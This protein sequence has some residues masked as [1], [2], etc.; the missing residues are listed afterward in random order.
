MSGHLSKRE[1]VLIDKHLK[2]AFAS[3]TETQKA[4]YNFAELSDSDGNVT[5]DQYE[6]HDQVSKFFESIFKNPED[7]LPTKLQLE[8]NNLQS[9]PLWQRMLEDDE[10]FQDIFSQSNIPAEIIKIISSAF[11]TTDANREKRNRAKE[12]VLKALEEPFTFE[13]FHRMIKRARGSSAGGIT[14]LSYGILKLAPEPLLEHLFEICARMWEQRYIPPYW[15]VKYLHLLVKDLSKSGLNNLRPIG[16][17]EVLRKIWSNLVIHRIRCAMYESQFFSPAQYGFISRKGTTDEL[18]Q[19]TN[20][21]EEASESNK[22]IEMTTWDITKAFDSVGRNIQFIT[23]LR[24]GV[25]IDVAKWFVDLDNGGYFIVRSPYALHHMRTLNHPTAPA[26]VVDLARQLGFQA[27]RGYTQGDVLSTTGWVGFFDILLTALEQLTDIGKFFY[28]TEGVELQAQDSMAYADDLVTVSANREQTDAY[29]EIICGFMAL[30]GLKLAPT[31]IRSSTTISPPGVLTYYDWEWRAYQR[32]FGNSDTPITILGVIMSASGSWEAQYEYLLLHCQRITQTVGHKL[33]SLSLKTKLLLCSTLAQILYRTQVIA[34]LPSQLDQ[35]NKVLFKVIRD[36]KDIG[37]TF[38]TQA[39]ITKHLGGIFTDVHS[40]TIKRKWSLQGRMLAIGGAQSKA[41]QSL[42]GRLHRTGFYDHSPSGQSAFVSTGL[43]GA[44]PRWGDDLPRSLREGIGLKYF[45]YQ[46]DDEDPLLSSMTPAP[47]VECAEVLE[48][49]SIYYRSELTPDGSTIPDWLHPRNMPEFRQG[50]RHLLESNLIQDPVGEP[51]AEPSCTIAPDQLYTFIGADYEEI[52]FEV[53]GILP[54]GLIA[55][56]RWKRVSRQSKKLVPC[57]EHDSQGRA[58]PERWDPQVIPLATSRRAIAYSPCNHDREMRL[59]GTHSQL[60]GQIP[61]AMESQTPPWCTRIIHENAITLGITSMIVSDASYIRHT[62]TMHS[63]FRT[64]V[65]PPNHAE[66]AF[67]LFKPGCIRPTLGI[68]IKGMADLGNYNAFVG[69][70]LTGLGAEQFRACLPGSIELRLDCASVISATGQRLPPSSDYYVNLQEDYGTVLSQFSRLRRNTNH[71]P[72]KWTRGHPDRDV[73]RKNG[74]TDHAIPRHEWGQAEYGI[75][76]ADHLADL[77]DRART[78][79][80]FEGLLPERIVEVSI[81]D[82]LAAIPTRGQWLRCPVATPN[83][84]LLTPQRE[85]A[86]DK[87]FID[88]CRRRD[89]LSNRPARWAIIQPGMLRP[90]LKI[91]GALGWAS[92]W[93]SYIRIILDKLPHNRNLMKGRLGPILPCQVCNRGEDS[94]EHL[95]R[96]EGNC[97]RTSREH[98]HGLLIMDIRSYCQRH[99][100][101]DTTRKVS[102]EYA[103]ALVSTSLS[104]QDTIGGWL[105][106]PN[107]RFLYFYHSDCDISQKVG[108]QFRQVLSRI[109]AE[110]IKW[111]QIAWRLRCRAAHAGSSQE[112][113]QSTRSNT[114]TR[115]TSF[116][117]MARGQHTHRTP[118]SERSSQTSLLP[119]LVDDLHLT[120]IEFGLDNDDGEIEEDRIEE[121]N[122]SGLSNSPEDID[123]MGVTA[124]ATPPPSIL[125]TY[126][127]N[128]GRPQRYRITNLRGRLIEG[129][130]LLYDLSDEVA[131]A[132]GRTWADLGN[133]EYYPLYNDIGLL[134]VSPVEIWIGPSRIPGAGLGLFIFT[135]YMTLHSGTGIGKYW[136]PSTRNGGI[137][138]EYAPEDSPIPEGTRDDGDYLLRHGSFLVDADEDCSMGYANEGWHDA[139]C[140]FQHTANNDPDLLLVL[141]KKLLPNRVYELTVNYGREYW[142]SGPNPR[143]FRLGAAARQLCELYYGG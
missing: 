95:I 47:S 81:Q 133:H 31:K 50:L 27:E 112:D 22:H 30:F 121:N 25:P 70:L 80:M 54:S 17:I 64:E 134:L 68:I 62:E 117:R 43:G 143:I 86:D 65:A 46:Q 14:G 19:L 129:E 98:F 9:M 137:P 8:Q 138:L 91:L 20:V 4:A 142:F 12:H 35:L 49:L 21:L 126:I 103:K 140:F 32:P 44:L 124:D 56:R 38:P 136:G 7:A 23:W 34:L 63:L 13:E 141:K 78:T 76:I 85:I 108:K 105:G 28:R 1:A 123:M 79:L 77:T 37:L 94:L 132:E 36:F 88:Y 59:L 127:D 113:S 131:F 18:I 119:H 90:S 116:H 42:L 2:R 106:I 125:P 10:V 83:I 5:T 72:I 61:P 115:L 69:E 111:L 135:S 93:A 15:R 33:A 6:I 60:R 24:M 73:L 75:Y 55:G 96:C 110:S 58:Y 67:V 39:L 11:C 107:P 74:T 104:E 84:P 52:F 41:M 3:L 97:I 82:I 40:A 114:T 102:I 51:R 71:P 128:T 100:F 53:S 87:I 26:E 101:S 130:P 122:I 29:A 139:N 66:G 118:G 120:P 57:Q 99:G 109:I 45:G 48:E 89:Q 92:K 16:L